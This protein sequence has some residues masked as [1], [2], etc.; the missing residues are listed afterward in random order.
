[1]VALLALGTAFALVALGEIG[2]KTQLLVVYLSTRY[3]RWAVLGGAIV[4]EVSMAAVATVIGVAAVALVPHPTLSIASAVVFIA[5]GA[6]LIV[7]R[8]AEP[9]AR[10]IRHQH[11]VF[12]ATAGIIAAG[13]VGDKTQ[14]VIIALAAQYVAPWEVF[15]G[16]SLAEG[17][18]M[19]IGVA[20]GIQLARR[21]RLQ[22]LRLISAGIFIVVGVLV[23]V[24]L[25][26]PGI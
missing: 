19:V 5:V 11:D 13:E 10:E 26:W 2:D 21:L 20:V 16:A 8:R 15:T 6:W 1:M 3:P 18:M 17:L 14:L 4:G 22:T 12:L 23:L 9:V 7:K 25:F 24:G